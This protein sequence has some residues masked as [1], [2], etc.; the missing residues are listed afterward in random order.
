MT[1][2]VAALIWDHDRFLAC[3]RP[4]SKARGLMWEF[5]GGKVEPGETKEAALIRECREELDV[6]VGVGEAFMELTHEYPDLTVHLTLFNAWITAGT[7]RM[8]E[9]NDIRWITTE[10][11]GNFDFCPADA[12]I[13]TRLKRVGNGLQARLFALRDPEYREFQCRLMPTVPPD[14]VIGVRTPDLRK[15]AKELYGTAGTGDFLG[16]LPHRFY[17]ENNLHGMLISGLK[18]Y[19]QTIGA[20]DAFLPYVDNWATCDLISPKSFQKHPAAL[21]P[22]IREWMK[23]EHPY[24]IRFGIGMLMKFY[25]DSEFAPEHLEWVAGVRSD[26]YYVN[27][28]VAWYFATALARQYDWA[29]SYIESRRLAPWTH[30]KTIQKALE[31][32]RITEEQKTYLR[33]W[34]I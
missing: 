19:G 31:S 9:H 11:I 32:H 30:N 18:D 26:A 15:L 14:T 25:L 13:L 16:N 2:V 21:L 24:T 12:A 28:M 1:E 22:K 7:P 17:E 5:V 29:I 3:Q 33:T 8:L 20:L 27:M 6:T 34:K 10:Q 4:A 23:S